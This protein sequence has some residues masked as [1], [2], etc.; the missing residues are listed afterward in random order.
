MRTTKALA[1]T[2]LRYFLVGTAGTGAYVGLYLIFAI[3]WTPGVA[4]V[5]AWFCSTV[6][7]NVVHRRVTFAITTP[8]RR[9]LDAMVQFATSLLGLGVSTWMIQATDEWGRGWHAPMLVLGTGIGGVVR[10]VCMKLWLD[11]SH[12]P[13]AHAGVPVDR[14]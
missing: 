2:F 7:T 5:V 6:A 3:W 13:T 11:R 12:S 8:R 4:T 14:A 1:L 9:L 10:F